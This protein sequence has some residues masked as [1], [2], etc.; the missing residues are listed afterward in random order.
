M[1]FDAVQPS[2]QVQSFSETPIT[3]GFKGTSGKSVDSSQE[4]YD[5]D[6]AYIGVLANETNYFD[7]PRMIASEQNEANSDLAN[8]LD[9]DK[10][11]YFNVVMSSTN[12]A[13]SPIIDTHRTSLIAISNKVNNPSET[14]LNVAS[15]DYNVLL[16]NATGVTISG[17][18]ITTSTQQAAFKTATVG[19]YLT[20]AGASTG[21]STK[22]ITAVAADGTS[23]TFDSA[24]TAVTGNVTLTQRE[25][26]VA[27]NAPAESSTFSKYLTKRINLANHCNYLRVRFAANL[28]AEATIEVWY[29]TN[30]VGSNVPF[31]NASYSQMTIESPIL[32]SSNA[33]NQ[34]YDAVYSLDDLVAFDAVQVKIVMKSS[35]SS[36]VPRIKDLRIIA[37]V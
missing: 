20:I 30:I 28:P 23:I 16:S 3:F 6:A 15:L 31:G 13:L 11:A 37:C 35:N 8:G 27:E 18:T 17:S 4:P 22:L 7:F 9:G 14:N 25:R 19:K 33:E 10:S 36:A 5:Q 34:F 21:T 2:V 1:Q 12:D 29:K 32:T 24:P 26:F